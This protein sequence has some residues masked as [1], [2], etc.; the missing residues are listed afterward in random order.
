[1]LD[2]KLKVMFCLWR[3]NGIQYFI[4]PKIDV[5]TLSKHMNQIR[6]GLRV[7]SCNCAGLKNLSHGNWWVL[8][9]L[10]ACIDLPAIK[11]DELKL[12]AVLVKAVIIPMKLW[13]VFV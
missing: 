3:E 6:A 10:P 5:S 11:N 9:M 4:C 13:L 2:Q 7:K 1:M 8:V 12:L